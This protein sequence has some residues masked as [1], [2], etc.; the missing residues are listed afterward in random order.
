M[1]FTG[2]NFDCELHFNQKVLKIIAA[3]VNL[4]NTLKDIFI[5]REMEVTKGHSYMQV[6]DK[7]AMPSPKH[8]ETTKR[9]TTLYITS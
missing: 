3:I 7:L 5:E 2:A 1:K 6:D 4:K 9:R 8:K